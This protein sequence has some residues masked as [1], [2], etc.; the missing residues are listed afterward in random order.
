MRREVGYDLTGWR[1]FAVLREDGETRTVSGGLGASVVETDLAG[2]TPRAREAALVGG[3]QGLLAPHGR[4]GGWGRG[5]GAPERRVPVRDVLEVCDGG[6]LDGMRFRAALRGLA[7]PRRAT[8][9]LAIPDDGSMDEGARD[10]R[11]AELRR[12][13]ARAALLVWRPVALALDALV[14][15]RVGEGAR[16]VVATHGAR[17]LSVQLLDLVEED[18]IVAPERRQAGRNWSWDG[19]LAVRRNAAAAALARSAGRAAP[20]VATTGLPVAAALGVDVPPELVRLDGGDWQILDPVDASPLPGL[21]TGFSTAI[22]SSDVLA[23]DTPLAG[24]ARAEFLALL[25][26]EHFDPDPGAVARGAAEAARRFAAGEPVFF[27][28]LPQI[29]TVVTGLRGTESFDLIPDAARL[30]AG[31]L[32]R[33]DRP[34]RLRI[35]AGAERIDIYLRKEGAGAPRRVDIPLPTPTTAEM[36]VSVSVEQMPAAGRAKVMLESSGLTHVLVANW[37]GAEVLP[38]TWDEVVAGAS[39]AAPTIPARMVL[40][41]GIDAWRARS[42]DDGLF[43][44]LHAWDHGRRPSWKTAVMSLNT[45]VDGRRTVDSDGQLPPGLDALAERSFNDLSAAALDVV[46]RRLDGRDPARSNEALLFLTWQFRRCP[47]SLVP[48]LISALRAGKGRHPFYWTGGNAAGMWQGIG[49]AATDPVDQRAAFDLL[50]D[51]PDHAWKKDQI[52]CAA[53]LLSRTDSAPRL[54]RPEEVR[55][56][57]FLVAS[58]IEETVR[59][60]D[61]GPRF[62]YLPFL[63]VGL[64]RHRLEEPWA[65]LAGQDEAADRLLAAAEA[66]CSAMARRTDIAG[67]RLLLED[68]CDEL[69]GQGRNPNLLAALSR[70]AR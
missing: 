45:T 12:A 5:V 63:F 33:S 66:A 53:F 26:A 11:L 29:S 24:E 22:G 15:G 67:R 20:L 51:L 18:G 39:A 70:E 9:A 52:A 34:A 55:R 41:C 64:L 37:E 14:Q 28:F 17:G 58:R 16:L 56:I 7:D 32:Y 25:G 30:R 68:A 4:G 23:A 40:P 44:L 61:F 46:T 13:G 36:E 2:A 62:M 49:R 54:L 21:P 19:G 1:D 69:R 38:G 59:N 10:W 57:G 3:V 60:G 42:G 35:L 50:R 65:L 31:Q 6:V 48:E 27:D 8:V 47:Q 43:A